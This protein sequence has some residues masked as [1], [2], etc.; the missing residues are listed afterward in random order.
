MAQ[1]RQSEMWAGDPAAFDAL[2]REYGPRLR[3]FLRQ[4]V[5]SAHA[6]EDLTQEL[7][8]QL[9][10]R[11]EGFDPQRGTLSAY[12]FGMAR[13]HA[14]EWWRRRKPEDL[15]LDLSTDPR[16]EKNFERDSTIG[17]ALGHLPEE[18]RALLWLREV[19]GQSYAELAEILKIPLGTV[20]SR[21]HAARE[22]LRQIWLGNTRNRKGELHEV[23]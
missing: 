10:R 14:A 15:G 17:D 12:L 9:W 1:N 21:L 16:T 23:R 11:P 13:H 2:Y 7:F 22:A 8:M 20:R 5:G 6:A 4:L 3:A 19:E 18:Q